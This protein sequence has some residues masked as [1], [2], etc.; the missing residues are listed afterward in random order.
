MVVLNWIYMYN[1]ARAVST[2]KYTAGTVRYRLSDYES[3]M[4]VVKDLHIV[5]VF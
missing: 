2:W 1:E 3:K 4:G 5:V